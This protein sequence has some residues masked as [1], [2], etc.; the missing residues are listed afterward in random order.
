MKKNCN[1]NEGK[2]YKKKSEIQK[3][4]NLYGTKPIYESVKRKGCKK[5]CCES[6]NKYKYKK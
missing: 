1:R 6:V 3:K 2:L 5:C 4:Q